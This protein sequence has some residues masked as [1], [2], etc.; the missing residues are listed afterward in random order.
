MKF[1][2]EWLEETTN[3]WVLQ[4]EVEEEELYT[5]RDIEAE[6][7]MSLSDFMTAW[8][9][10]LIMNPKEMLKHLNMFE[11]EIKKNGEE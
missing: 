6:L 1:V 3:T 8:F 7:G 5:I 10:A 11:G 2:K 9:K 4:F